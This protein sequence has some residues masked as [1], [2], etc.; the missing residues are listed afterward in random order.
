MAISVLIFTIWYRVQASITSCM[1]FTST[2]H[3]NQIFTVFMCIDTTIWNYLVHLKSYIIMKID[4]YTA[5]F[6]YADPNLSICDIWFI[7]LLISQYKTDKLVLLYF[8]ILF[9]ICLTACDKICILLS[10]VGDCYSSF[11]H[12]YDEMHNINECCW[13]IKQTSKIC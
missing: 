5:N 13:K 1:L 2:L 10:K 6:W 8:Y 12:Q 9:R 4:K 7:K 11:L 3:H